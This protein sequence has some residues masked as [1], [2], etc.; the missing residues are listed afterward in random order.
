MKKKAAIKN[1][2]CNLFRL[3]WRKCPEYIAVMSAEFLKL[4]TNGY[5]FSNFANMLCIHVLLIV[6]IFAEL[7]NSLSSGSSAWLL[8]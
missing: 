4:F 2:S 3:S 6:N 5:H 7:L 8:L 1:L